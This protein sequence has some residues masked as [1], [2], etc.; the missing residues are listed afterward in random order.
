MSKF[1]ALAV[2]L[3]LYLPLMWFNSNVARDRNFL[4]LS[5]AEM[6]VQAFFMLMP[7]VILY[8]LDKNSTKTED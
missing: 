3:F 4:D 5:I 6:L 1:L 8:L 7:L 2:M